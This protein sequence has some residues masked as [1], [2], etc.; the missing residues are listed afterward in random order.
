MKILDDLVK[1]YRDRLGEGELTVD[2]TELYSNLLT[3]Q[4]I[5]DCKEYEYKDMIR[6][7]VYML[8][9]GY[10]PHSFYNAS[11]VNRAKCLSKE[12]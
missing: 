4:D 1:H 3:L 6:I 2:T 11:E 7:L 10:D 12:E 5:F 8:E 9:N